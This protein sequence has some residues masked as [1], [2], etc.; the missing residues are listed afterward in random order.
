MTQRD[1]E[2]TGSIPRHDFF[3]KKEFIHKPVLSPCFHMGKSASVG[4]ED[5]GGARLGEAAGEG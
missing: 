4:G 1:F 5:D 2:R 3:H